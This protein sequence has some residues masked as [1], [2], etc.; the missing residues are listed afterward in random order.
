MQRTLSMKNF[1]QELEGDKTYTQIGYSP[2]VGAIHSYQTFVGPKSYDAVSS[3]SIVQGNFKTPNHWSYEVIHERKPFGTNVWNI[4]YR[5][6][7]W[8]TTTYEGY[9]ATGSASDW[10]NG[11]SYPSNIYNDA[12][13]KLNEKTRG[14]LDLSVALAEA[15]ATVRMFNVIKT[16]TEFLKARNW[17]QI[18]KNVANARLEYAYGWK[19]LASDIYNALDQSIS[20]ALNRIEHFEVST[21]KTI[22]DGPSTFDFDN[23]GAITKTARRTGK[24][25][26]KLSIAL[27]TSGNDIDKW[28]SLN[29]ISIA[30]ELL[31]YS[32]VVDWFIDVGSYLRNLETSLLYANKF[33]SGYRTE[34]TFFDAKWDCAVTRSSGWYPVYTYS[35]FASAAYKYRKQTRTILHSYPAPKLPSF[36]VDLGSGRLLNAAAL[37]MQLIK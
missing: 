29:P 5:G 32:F 22:V 37:L 35:V 27:D 23:Y 28:T 24:H 36:E 6:N 1:T 13:S 3:S 31:P 15:G 9:I 18:A 34:C 21:Y 14:N 12:L 11:I 2:S 25:I 20:I 16:G 4:Y 30:W 8:L 7:N 19:P 10:H 33:V 17:R 26:C